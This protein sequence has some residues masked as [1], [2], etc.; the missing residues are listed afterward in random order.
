M[1]KEL[2]ISSVDILQQIKLSCQIPE[3]VQAIAN[4]KIVTD[5]ANQAG[6]KVETTELQKAADNLRVANKLLK[7]EDTWA[8]L[9][10]HHLAVEEFE[11]LAETNLL[12]AKL[13]SHLFADKV[14]PFFYEN[15]LNYVAAAI[16]EVVLDDED[17]A[18]ELF[19]ALQEG[20]ISFAEIARQYIQNPELRRAGGY[21]GVKTRSELRPEIAAAVFACNPPGVIKPIVTPKGVHL[22]WVE[23]I[24][25]PQLN[26]LVRLKILSDLFANWLKQQSSTWNINVDLDSE[27]NSSAKELLQQV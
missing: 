13:A 5:A 25:Q 7:A 22:I 11:L 24:I 26:D 16:Y 15:Q 19:Y 14:E 8:W 18:L 17:L 6:I 20:E 23:E 1:S 27:H 3:L 4:R 9:K 21:L 10:K 2:K 12:S